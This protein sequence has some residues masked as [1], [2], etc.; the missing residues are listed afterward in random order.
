MKADLI[1]A[2]G[3]LANCLIAYRVRERRPDLRVLVVEQGARLGGSHTW[4]FHSSDLSEA[5]RR[6]T[7]PFIEH[8]WPYYD[9][10]FPRLRRR[11]GGGYHAFTDASLHAVASAALGDSVRLDQPLAV[12]APDHVITQSGQ[13][14]D[15]PAVIDGR[16]DPRD[17]S[18]TLGFQKFAG[19]VLELER[20]HGL[21]GPVLMD[22]TGAHLDGY[23]F[24]YTLPFGPRTVLVEDTRYSDGPGLQ[25]EEMHKEVR[26]YARERYGEIA[27]TVHEEQGVLPIVLC[28][29]IHAFWRAGEPG[30]PRAGMRAALFNQVTGYSFPD[31]VRLADAICDQPVFESAAL[32][33]W[34]REY[35]IAAWSRQGFYR[36]LNRMLFW[37]GKP[38]DRFQIL[39]RFYRLPEPLI[40][41]FYAGQ[42]SLADKLRIVSGKPPVPLLEA[43]R[44]MAAT[45]RPRANNIQTT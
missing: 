1:L 41:R 26:A 12:V 21:E 2:G 31:A 16:G 42:S 14:Y 17:A 8:S 23:R 10:R 29:D 30:V 32:H 9:V 3:G 40:K 7:A 45:S 24:L 37:A 34:I 13:R 28:G 27:S 15:A 19:L 39:E 5:Q 43:V 33:R 44:C 11:L 6:W 36:L 38:D 20:P 35:S 4:C 22:A 25:V 18:L